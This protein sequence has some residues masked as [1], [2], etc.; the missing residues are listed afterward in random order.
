MANETVSRSNN[1]ALALTAYFIACALMILA[2]GIFMAF[3][4]P[5]GKIVRAVIG[6][7]PYRLRRQRALA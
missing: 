7:G 2:G 1:V 4:E 5:V 6:P 3:V